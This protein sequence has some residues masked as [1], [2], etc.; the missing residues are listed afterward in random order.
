MA[1]R[2]RE[3]DVELAAGHPGDGAVEV[4]TCQTRSYY[5]LYDVMGISWG[6]SLPYPKRADWQA[7][8]SLQCLAARY[9]R[10]ID[11]PG[12]A[13]AMAWDGWMWIVARTPRSNR[14][15]LTKPHAAIS[16]WSEITSSESR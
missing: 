12:S 9:K 14:V 11:V 8:I 1:G 4:G 3:H 2:R 6:L 10:P 16:S 5:D 7:Q 15:G 13:P